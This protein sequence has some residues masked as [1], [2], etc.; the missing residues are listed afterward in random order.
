[1]KSESPEGG[2]RNRLRAIA[3]RKM[4]VQPS[5]DSGWNKQAECLAILSRLRGHLGWMEEH[6]GTSLQAVEWPLTDTTAQF[7]S[8]HLAPMSSVLS[9][10]KIAAILNTCNP[11]SSQTMASTHSCVMCQGCIDPCF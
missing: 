5:S 9:L 10:V 3:T 7:K 1:M 11:A 2:L 6:E 8:Q 4:K